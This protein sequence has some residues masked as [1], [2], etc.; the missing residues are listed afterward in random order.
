MMFI[1]CYNI[2]GNAYFAAFGVPDLEAI[3]ILNEVVESLFLIDLL[4]C[5]VQEYQD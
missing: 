3:R 1:S 4:L 5:F 2:F